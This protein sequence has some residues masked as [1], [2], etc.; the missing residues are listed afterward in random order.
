MLFST[1]AGAFADLYDRRLVQLTA[2]ALSFASAGTLTAITWAGGTSPPLLLMFTFLIGSGAAVFS[3]AWQVSIRGQVPPDQMSAAI[4][5][6]SVS[7]NV[8]RSLGPAIGGM[9]VAFAGSVAAF[10]TA[11]AFYIRMLLVVL[12]SSPDRE[13]HSLPPEPTPRAISTGFR[14]ILHSPVVRTVLLRSLAVGLAGGGVA[15]LTPVIARDLLHGRSGV[16][17]ILLASYGL[18]AV[19]GAALLTEAQRWMSAETATRWCGIA[20]ALGA[21]VAGLSNDLALTVVALLVAGIAW[22]LLAAFFNIGI[23]LRAPRWVAARVIAGFQATIAGGAAIGSWMWGEVSSR[24]GVADGLVGIAIAM[25]V[26]T[27]AGG[28]WLRMPDRIEEPRE[29]LEPLADPEIGLDLTDYS[30]PVEVEIHYHLD[31]GAAGPFREVMREVQ[32]TGL[33]N[34]AQ[35]WSLARDIADETLWVERFVCATWLDYLRQRSRATQNERELQRR[36]MQH[37]LE[38]WPFRVTRRLVDRNR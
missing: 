38:N 24:L 33:H 13:A 10:A 7:Y 22:M 11:A 4:A 9:V 20:L 35:T 25:V 6:R 18:G 34:G 36:T 3:P 26:V 19:I 29:A 2:L 8:G 14:Y 32:R 15:A 1:P 21:L 27:L 16:Y 37:Q 31:P 28:L 5:L 23:Q 17:G 30:G 12:R